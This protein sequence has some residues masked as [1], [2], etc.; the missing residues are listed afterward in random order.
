MD[1]YKEVMDAA[2]NNLASSPEK[3]L[4]IRLFKSFEYDKFQASYDSIA[5]A[6]GSNKFT[7]RAQIKGLEAINAMTVERPSEKGKRPGTAILI[8]KLNRPNKWG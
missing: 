7:V 5:E 1:T 6:I 3:I 4:W 8:I 2:T